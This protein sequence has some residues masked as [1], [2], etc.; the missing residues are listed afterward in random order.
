MKQLIEK[1]QRDIDNSYKG[2]GTLCEANL[3]RLLTKIVDLNRGV[4]GRE[5]K[6]FSSIINDFA[7][8]T[9]WRGERTFS[10]NR[11][12]NDKLASKLNS[13][14]LGP[15][16]LTGY[17]EETDIE[18]GAKVQRREDP[19][20]VVKDPKIPTEDFIDAIVSLGGEFEQEAVL[21]GITEDGVYEYLMS[22]GK[23]RRLEKGGQLTLNKVGRAY[24][25][26]KKKPDVPFIFEGVRQPSTIFG[27][28][29]FRGRGYKYFYD[30]ELGYKI[31]DK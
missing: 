19:F 9:A 10:V 3:S 26:M 15:Y 28:Q 27:Y 13:Q 6:S 12:L 5:R 21:I 31:G 17:W 25:I 20:L 1:I 14:R 11:A 30:G 23:P 4:K 2:F 24:S 16:L 7:I 8:L 29:A 22:G 18:T